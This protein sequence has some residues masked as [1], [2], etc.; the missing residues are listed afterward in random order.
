MFLG[1]VPHRNGHIKRNVESVFG[2]DILRTQCFR[3][4]YLTIFSTHRA[5]AKFRRIS[6]I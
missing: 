1:L 2:R 6:N 5:R 4:A 3:F